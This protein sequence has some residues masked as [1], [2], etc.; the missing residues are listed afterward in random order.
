MVNN[1]CVTRRTLHE[2]VTTVIN[3]LKWKGVLPNDRV[4]MTVLPS[5]DFYAVAIAVLAV[6]ELYCKEWEGRRDVT[7]GASLQAC[8]VL[9]CQVS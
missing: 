1:Q 7:L 9:S 6:G 4:L 5:V 3:L 8:N 2:K